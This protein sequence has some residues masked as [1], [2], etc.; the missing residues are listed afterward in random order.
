MHRCSSKVLVLQT[1]F[2]AL[3]AISRQ[4]HQHQ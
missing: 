1:Q 4:Q 3:S 2:C